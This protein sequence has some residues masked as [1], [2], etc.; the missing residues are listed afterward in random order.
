MG[1]AA[2][3]VLLYKEVFRGAPLD[4]APWP[5]S[6][7]LNDT[8]H[9]SLLKLKSGVCIFDLRIRQWVEYLPICLVS[10]YL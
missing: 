7:Q 6:Y 1:G 3:L 2:L 4:P 9:F 10:F 5:D 8:Q